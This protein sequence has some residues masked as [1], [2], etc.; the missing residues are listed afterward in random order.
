MKGKGEGINVSMLEISYQLSGCVNA[1]R[2]GYLATLHFCLL[3]EGCD[4]TNTL[5]ASAVIHTRLTFNSSGISYRPFVLN[6]NLVF[7]AHALL[8]SQCCGD[9]SMKA[10]PPSHGFLDA[11]N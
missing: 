11:F 8:D 6:A 1:M 4:S 2:L 9:G 3:Q 7:N 10:T 5:N